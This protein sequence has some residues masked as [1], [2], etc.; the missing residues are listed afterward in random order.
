MRKRSIDKLL[1]FCLSVV[2]MVAFGAMPVMAEDALSVIEVKAVAE[3]LQEGQ[4]VTGVRIEYPGTV[5]AGSVSLTS[6]TVSGYSVIGVYTNDSGEPD[7][8]QAQGKYVFLKLAYSTVPGY[9]MGKTLQYTEGMNLLREVHLD[10][11]QTGNV[12]LADERVVAANGF[13][14]DGTI[15]VLV[16][17]FIPV[18]FTNPADGT[19]LDY[20][21][22]VPEGYDV[23]ADGQQALPLVVFLH[24]AGESGFNN[25]SQILGNPSA[26][27]FANAE[28]QA[29]HPASCSRLR[30]RTRPRTAGR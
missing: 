16:D 26:L 15:N 10:I 17:D 23:K 24:G 4:T 21:L 20:R 13:T 29:A 27:E 5:V 18:T 6:Y 19:T 28:A 7:V 22:Y 2:M 25:I 12:T 30:R 1:A 8:A 11:R 14:N 9:S 3:T